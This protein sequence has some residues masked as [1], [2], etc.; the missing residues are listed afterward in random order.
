[1]KWVKLSKFYSDA[2]FSFPFL[3][4]VIRLLFPLNTIWQSSCKSQLFAVF[5][6]N[7]KVRLRL[8]C[9]VTFECLNF[10]QHHMLASHSAWYRYVGGRL[11]SL[12]SIEKID[13]TNSMLNEFSILLTRAK[14]LQYSPIWVGMSVIG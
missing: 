3:Q 8:V 7:L 10:S 2:R 11:F 13:V 12:L 5:V 14:S 1:M 4:F 6:L 9:S